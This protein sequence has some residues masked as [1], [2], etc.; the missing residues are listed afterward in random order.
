MS[1]STLAET[2]VAAALCATT[3]AIASPAASAPLAEGVVSS[4]LRFPAA[5]VAQR[6]ARATPIVES[7]VPEFIA[8]V[9]EVVASQMLKRAGD[10]AAAGNRGR[11]EPQHLRSAVR[12]DDNLAILVGAS[13][14]DQ[15]GLLRPDDGDAQS[16]AAGTDGEAAD[17]PKADADDTDMN[18]VGNEAAAPAAAAADTA[19]GVGEDEAS[20]D[21]GFPTVRVAERMMRTMPSVAEDAS[22]FMAAV[23]EV[24]ASQMLQRAGDAAAAGS[25]RRI[26]PQHLRSAVR[27]DDNLAILVGA[28]ALDEGGLLQPAEESAEPSRNGVIPVSDPYS[29]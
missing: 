11:I 5:R 18:T 21:R 1:C 28:S 20:P 25:S 23:L 13:A 2:A 9:L 19:A 4:R 27:A 22:S 26:E 8:A 17:A 14:L 29:F 16:E 12:A 10:A 24:V 15:G 6:I 3:A 7:D